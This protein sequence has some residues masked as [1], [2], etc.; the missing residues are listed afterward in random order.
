MNVNE[1]RPENDLNAL[2]FSLSLTHAHTFS[3]IHRLL[4]DL[5]HPPLVYYTTVDDDEIRRAAGNRYR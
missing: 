3:Y 5:V 2:I 4:L 1:K